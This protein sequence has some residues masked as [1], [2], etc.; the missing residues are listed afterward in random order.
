MEK[1][2]KT[3]KKSVNYQ[4]WEYMG[5]PVTDEMA[6]PDRYEGFVYIMTHKPSGKRYIGKKSFVS[7][8][9]LKPTDKKK[10]RIESNWKSYFSSSDDIKEYVQGDSKKDWKREIIYL[11]EK[12]KYA[13]YL[14]VKL[15]FAYGVLE[16]DE[17]FN[18]NINGLFYSHWL[19]DIKTEVSGKDYKE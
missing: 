5:S 19:K 12:M 10:T 4:P 1:E 2:K 3:R 16:S 11:C 9:K 17:W 15:Q 8:R 13:N 7:V 14:E 18:S 6:L